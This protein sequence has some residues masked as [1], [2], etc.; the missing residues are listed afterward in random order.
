D[1]LDTAVSV[2]PKY[3]YHGPFLELVMTEDLFMVGAPKTLTHPYIDS[4][5]DYCSGSPIIAGTR[6]P[7]RAV[8]QYV[9]KQGLSPEELVREFSQLTLAQVYDA[10]SYYYDHTDAIEQELTQNTEARLRPSA[11]N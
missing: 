3:Q 1:L 4:H 7:V 11:N 5:K 8:V 10:L 9:I 2:S 6:F